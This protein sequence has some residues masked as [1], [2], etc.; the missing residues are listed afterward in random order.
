MKKFNLLFLSLFIVIHSVWCQSAFLDLSGLGNSSDTYVYWFDID[1]TA[2]NSISLPDGQFVV[3]V[4]HLAPGSHILHGYLMNSQAG[5]TPV[6][7]SLPFYIP[8]HSLVATRLAYWFDNQT[9]PSYTTNLSENMLWNVA[10]LPTGVHTL[11]FAPAD[12]S[13][14]I[15][16]PH[17]A[18][19]FK[20]ELADSLP[21]IASLLYW[22]DNDTVLT[23]E[24]T[25]EG[26]RG[27]DVS[28][29]T[30]GVHFVNMMAVYD[31][32][33]V[34]PAVSNTFYANLSSVDTLRNDQLAYWFD[35][36][37]DV[38]Y[39]AFPDSA[40]RIDVSNLV[41]GVHVLHTQAI[42]D[43]GDRSPSSIAAPFYANL[44]PVDTLRNNQLA[45]WFDDNEDVSYMAFPDS[46]VRIDVSDLVE[47]V[48]VLHTQ[49]IYD[50]GDRSP[51]SIAVPFYANLSHD[52]FAADQ[53]AYWFD[54]AQEMS[55]MPISEEEV[56]LD[57][58]DLIP[59][60]HTLHCLASDSENGIV[61][62]GKSYP[63]MNADLFDRKIRQASYWFNDS[64]VNRH[65]TAFSYLGDTLRWVAALQTDSLPIRSTNFH[66]ENDTAPMMFA[67]DT[68]GFSFL[69]ETGAQITSDSYGFVNHLV[70][71]RV[72]ADTLV[73][74]TL[75]DVPSLQTD[76]VK[77]YCFNA[78]IG[79]VVTLSSNNQCTMQLYDPEAE[80]VLYAK[81]DSST[82]QN[83]LEVQTSGIHW[84]AVHDMSMP[85]YTPHQITYRLRSSGCDYLTA[86]ITE[87]DNNSAKVNADADVWE[88]ALGNAGTQ[89]SECV[90]YT[91][92]GA[93]EFVFTDLAPSTRYVVYVRRSCGS[94]YGEWSEAY[95]FATN[96]LCVPLTVATWSEGAENT[97]GSDL[98]ECWATGY[99][100]NVASQTADGYQYILNQNFDDLTSGVP[101]GWDDSDYDCSSSYRW[102]SDAGGYGGTRG[103]R[104]NSY[105][106]SNG[107]HSALMTPLLNIT[108]PSTLRFRYSNYHAGSLDVRI[109]LDGGAT[110]TTVI[111]SGLETSMS[112]EWA[113]AEY[114]LASY[115]GQSNVR[116]VFYSVSNYG[117]SRQYLDDVVIV[118]DVTAGDADSTYQQPFV[119][120]SSNVH[121][122]SR[123]FK[124]RDLPS[125]NISYLTSP[126]FTIDQPNVYQA[127]IWIYRPSGTSFVG[128]GLRLFA[129]NSPDDVTDAQ[130]LGFI[131]RCAGNAP[132]EVL[133]EGTYGG[134]FK[135]SFPIAKTGVV[136]LIIQGESKYG[137]A[138]NFDD[139]A[140]EL[141]PTCLVP[142]D[143]ALGT[144]T[145]TGNT[146]SW[147][148]GGDESSW[149]LAYDLMTGSNVVASDS[150]TVTSP[151]YTFTNL[152]EATAYTVNV[153]VY[154][155]CSPSDRSV[156]QVF[157]DTFTT[158]SSSSVI[159]TIPY[160]CGFED[161]A[162]NNQWTIVNGAS[163]TNI[164]T[165]GTDANAVASGS[166][167]LYIGNGNTYTYSTSSSTK[168]FA[169]RTIYFGSGVHNVSFRFK[170]TGG[171]STYDY[172]SV[173]LVPAS[174]TLNGGNGSFVSST[175]WPNYAEVF[176]PISGQNHFNL[177]EGDANGWNTYSGDIDMTGREGTYN[178]VVMWNNDGSTGNNY[179]IS[180]DDVII[181]QVAIT[182]CDR[183]SAPVTFDFE[184][185]YTGIGNV[186]DCWDN[187]DYIAGTSTTSSNAYLW[188]VSSTTTVAHSGS[189][190]AYLYASK[191][192]TVAS[193]LKTPIINLPS[194]KDMKVSFWLRN[195]SSANSSGDFGLYVSTDGGATYLQ[196]PLAQHVST[197][198][199]WTQYE[200]SLA[201]FK[202]QSVTLVFEGASDASSSYFYY[203]DDISVMDAP[204]CLVPG[205]IALGTPTTTGNTISWTA[206][207]DES[208]WVL[209]YDLMTGS[210]V[211]ASDSVTVT[212][213]SYTFTNLS[214]ATAYTV[215]VRVYAL[216]SPSDR[217]VPQVFS[218]TFTTASSSSV[219]ATIPY[220]CGFED[221][222]E[223][224][225]WTIV[226]GASTTNIFT[227]GTDA[228]AVASGSKALYIGN[229]N[230]YTYSTGSSTK[231]FAYR[232]IYFGSGVHNVT[233]RFKC[234]G[235]ESTWDFASIMLVPASETL[236]GSTGSSVSGTT[237][238]NFTEIFNPIE[239]QNYF[240]LM[241]GDANG[242]NTYNTDIDMTGREGTYNFVVM[243]SNDGSAGT[244]N[245]PIS[246]DNLSI[247][248]VTCNTPAVL[249]G[250]TT[251]TG[252]TISVGSQTATQWE[253]AV[254]TTPIDVFGTVTGDVYQQVTSAPVV[255]N[256]LMSNT[257]YYYTARAICGVGD[258]SKW[259]DVQV[260]KT[261]CSPSVVPYVE[262]FENQDALD[263]WRIFGNVPSVLS[264]DFSYNGSSS[265]KVEN[266]TA[267]SPVFDVNSLADLMLTGWCFSTTDNAQFTIGA[268]VDP[269]DAS[270]FLA[271][272]EVTIPTKN[273]WTEFTTYFNT[274][275]SP[276]YADFQNAKHFAIVAGSGNPIYLDDIWFVNIPTCPKPTNAV[277]TNVLSNSFDIAWTE[278]GTATSWRIRAIP[279]AEGQAVIDK[280]VTTNH[281]NVE[282]LNAASAYDVEIQAI[283]SA[284]DTSLV[285]NCGRIKTTCDVVNTPYEEDFELMTVQTIPDCWDNTGSTTST[286]TSTPYYVWGVYAQGGNQ[287]IRMYNYSV[288]TGLATINSPVIAIPA[289]GATLYFDLC[290]QATSGD[291]EV[292]ISSDGGANWTLL[293]SYAMTNAYNTDYS[294][295]FAWENEQIDLAAYAGRNVIIRF[296]NQANYGYG[297][298]FI[299]NVSVRA[300]PVCPTP[301]DLKIIGAATMHEA[302]ISWSF[303]ET[304]APTGWL[305]AYGP[306]GTPI[307][308][309]TVVEVTDTFVEL[310]GLIPA[311]SYDF[312]VRCDCNEELHSDWSQKFTFSTI[313]PSV[314][315][316]PYVCGFEDDDENDRWVI[317]DGDAPD[318]YNTFIFGSDDDAIASGSKALYIQ[319]NDVGLYGG[320]YR[321]TSYFGTKTFAYRTIN[322]GSGIYNVSFRWKLP[323]GNGDADFA[324][325]MLVPVSETIVGGDGVNYA[326]TVFPNYIEAFDPDGNN[327]MSSAHGDENGWNVYNA[328]IDMRG[329][330][331][332]YNFVVMWNNCQDYRR[333]KGT[334]ISIDDVSIY[335]HIEYADT[336]CAGSD[337]EWHGNLYSTTGV[338]YD[339]TRISDD[340]VYK[341]TLTVLTHYYVV[342][343]ASFYEYEMPIYYNNRYIWETG[344]YFDTLASVNGCDSIVEFRLTVIESP[345]YHVTVLPI[346][347]EAGTVNQ[348]SDVVV[349][350]DDVQLTAYANRNYKFVGW[351]DGILEF[352]RYF[353]PYSDTTI[354]AY[355]EPLR[356]DTAT[357][358]VSDEC[359][360]AISNTKYDLYWAMQVSSGLYS[361][362]D[363]ITAVMYY[364]CASAQSTL[365]VKKIDGD[366]TVDVYS[367]SVIMT[368]S[369]QWV[370]IPLQ[371]PV[372]CSVN[373]DMI[374]GF[375][376]PSN[377]NAAAVSRYSANTN[378][379]LV[380]ND[381]YTWNHINDYGYDVT[382]MIKVL[383]TK[384]TY[385]NVSVISVPSGTGSVKPYNHLVVDGSVVSLE[386][387]AN[388]NYKFVGWSTGNEDYKIAFIP[389]CD[390]TIYAHFEP[391]GHDTT[392][393]CVSDEFMGHLGFEAP[394]DFYWAMLVNKGLYSDGDSISSVMYFDC[395]PVQSTLYF[396]KF[397]GDSIVNIYSQ[398][399]VMTGSNQWVT[400]PLQ[401]PVPCSANTDMLIGFV[402]P[403]YNYAAAFSR[404]S[405]NPNGSLYSQDDFNS[406]EYL[407]NVGFEGTWMIKAILKESPK[408]YVVVSQT[409]N[410]CQGDAFSWHG[411]N[412]VQTGIYRD[413]VHTIAD[414]DTVYELTLTV[415]Y[416][417]FDVED[418]T[419]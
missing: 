133:E 401:T 142:G 216:C 111:A 278:N 285:T 336:I 348:S 106:A 330:E 224:N 16:P 357:Y 36:N 343:S 40:V 143:I 211:V 231:T 30:E 89:V 352:S 310:S 337:Y 263:C 220:F 135:Y 4:S 64:V 96:S 240:N 158:A 15:A 84:L 49:A 129:G 59:G 242:W 258:T 162:E 387:S 394:V 238:P 262:D 91:V 32:G 361:E 250:S 160:F 150:V 327:K 87:V 192:Y 324:R 132:V 373:A 272:G 294:M 201:A 140:V 297:A 75:V 9:E 225:Q 230:T 194:A 404:Y 81:G 390:T 249:S 338:Y 228:N 312:Y 264:T 412:L 181:Q 328:D 296:A 350:G 3:D 288:R 145:T 257:V 374:I 340:T 79:D 127:S 265:V 291:M 92:T 375:A 344:V 44:S 280:V 56:R 360:D 382:W 313:T 317:V 304:T 246:I 66:F 349:Y 416:P 393:Y 202:G 24:P 406:W 283:C 218:D 210:N 19:F 164:F 35:D 309:M 149:V 203:L 200:Y 314:A 378:G 123:S 103:L 156:P 204:T 112:D 141:A 418:V 175:T 364:D 300:N 392:T 197:G 222:A 190:Y 77:W 261:F 239:G 39:M 188:Y 419:A 371:A 277:I 407:P 236:V 377:I 396:K 417:F 281:A 321:Y 61:Y 38:S 185:S 78:A 274:L 331:G 367:Q 207:G 42:Y 90:V 167:A 402:I 26:T 159:A 109:S 355:F 299:D 114:S 214:E 122:G 165:F 124:L 252:T 104:F 237:W 48:H 389:Y 209:A 29:F 275:A 260:F 369:N 323:D 305:C 41:E 174:E 76:E 172:A 383:T 146:I 161:D 215:N 107:T 85:T 60:V 2:Q 386:S 384:I 251:S 138:T 363:S 322:F 270:T 212:S 136:Y 45:Y 198:N 63:F 253:V 295:P 410:I 325:V 65:D 168:T 113:E 52:T 116:I 370:T 234:T 70:G 88:V 306:A 152:S 10:Q 413:T 233:F 154:A 134:W 137:A 53:I 372:P 178:F 415:T 298:I 54:D 335:H 326:N 244:A 189:K 307:D 166:K 332:L 397:E 148:A 176:S 25:V 120:Q 110:Y 359:Y 21:T 173:M 284:T 403:G 144:P 115:V 221:D 408:Q 320:K 67:C 43:N 187:Q 34:S 100:N 354:Y 267:V 94:S 80:R 256:N 362:N 303:E 8:N 334:P 273:T 247:S 318:H 199:V 259:A 74:D 58:T 125:G 186:P 333:V 391:L 12:D 157:S 290:H 11:Y 17:S 286:A 353:T 398:S 18:S 409:A 126:G 301:T 255:L 223:N 388:Q 268:M 366:S 217:S 62:P 276:G 414:H 184:S 72:E 163:T 101:S 117:S 346:P 6:S 177:I 219:I 380:S 226:N 269:D 20:V 365:Y 14:V 345:K 147:T 13:T 182:G 57:V 368:G 329:R 411:R 205:D 86:V 266:G 169:Y 341:L 193:R 171:E 282:G 82:M 46:V 385:H 400:V 55:Y 232:T 316:I 119:T 302:L 183:V 405:A 179:P 241:P 73:S 22:F 151:S 191:I 71:K 69:S 98:P 376:V 105:S 287:M 347:A 319:N 213:P 381:G 23:A 131:N 248:Q 31:N 130:E 153:R 243:W 37:E 93:N 139:V 195:S 351:S 97:S 51:S 121:S 271:L 68:I 108:A 245:Y 292:L 342:D 95:S 196:N 155:L 358:C 339:S 356:T 254:S 7:T 229:G 311:T 227:F 5:W 47:G 28:S 170:C 118:E 289:T 102:K 180:I 33:K 99:F 50:N 399:V 83:E 315:T 279:A 128:E 208:S 308:E 293:G 206:G 1:A 395:A 235:G 379:S 27:Y